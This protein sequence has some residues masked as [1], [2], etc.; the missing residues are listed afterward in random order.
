MAQMKEQIKTP[1]KELS[2]K[3]TEN[4]SDAE[5][6]TLAIRMLTELIELDHKMEEEI[7]AAQSEIK[8]NIQWANREGKE[9]GTQINDLEQKEEINIQLEQNEETRIQKKKKKKKKR[10]E[11]SEPLGQN[12]QGEVKN[13]TGN[14]EAKELICMTHGHELRQGMLEDGGEQEEGD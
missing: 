9:T 8:E 7:K 6:K 12:R 11:A 5:F 13:S 14:R 1:E 4:L 2:N 10:R 3:E